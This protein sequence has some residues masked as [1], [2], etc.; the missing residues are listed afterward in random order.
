MAD[1]LNGNLDPDGS[2]RADDRIYVAFRRT[3]SIA[4]LCV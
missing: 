2:P 3:C 1:I 4:L